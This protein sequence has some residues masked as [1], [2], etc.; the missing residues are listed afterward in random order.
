MNKFINVLIGILA[1][2]LFIMC[3]TGCLPFQS[4]DSGYIFPLKLLEDNRFL[5]DQNGK[6]FFWSGDAARLHEYGL[7]SK[8]FQ[9][10]AMASSYSRFRS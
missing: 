7:C 6:P 5:I 3:M 1:I 10:K 8:T 9:V 2:Q 4:D